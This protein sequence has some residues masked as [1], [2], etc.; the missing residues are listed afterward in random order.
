MIVELFW[1]QSSSLLRMTV[2]RSQDIQGSGVDNKGK[3]VYHF[4]E[5]VRRWQSLVNWPILGVQKL[6][7]SEAFSRLISPIFFRAQESIIRPSLRLRPRNV[8]IGGERIPSHDLYVL[9][10]TILLLS[11][12]SL[13]CIHSCALLYDLHIDTIC[14][15]LPVSCPSFALW[16]F[17]SDFVM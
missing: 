11:G 3:H 15:D 13:S 9:P 1:L 2:S 10:S 7:R 14:Q 6:G 16:H 4:R 17:S 8:N 5:V 12:Q